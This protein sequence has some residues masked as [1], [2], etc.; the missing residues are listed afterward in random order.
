MRCHG[1]SLSRWLRIPL[2]GDTCDTATH[3]SPL[4]TSDT[5][6]EVHYD[7]V[8]KLKAFEITELPG[9]RA[10]Y[11]HFPKKAFAWFMS[12]FELFTTDG[13]SCISRDGS[14]NDQFPHI[15]P[16]TVKDMLEQYWKAD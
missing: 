7:S 1:T 8:E 5:K 3:L 6:F 12:I 10:L 4:T 14:L 15:K 16:L 13:Q 9:H 11:E 2:V